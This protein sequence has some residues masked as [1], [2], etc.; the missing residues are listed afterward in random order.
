M[1]VIVTN[2][3]EL[4]EDVIR[5]VQREIPDT[6]VHLTDAIEKE[7]P[8]FEDK[9]LQLCDKQLQEYG[10]PAPNRDHQTTTS[11]ILRETSYTTDQLNG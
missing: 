9:V 6:D 3:E 7:A 11:E 2:K 5:R 4:C 1:I 10:L 8:L